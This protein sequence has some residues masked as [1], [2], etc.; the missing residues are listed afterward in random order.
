MIKRISGEDLPDISGNM[1]ELDS[2]LFV[3]FKA[4]VRPNWLAKNAV[5]ITVHLADLAGTNESFSSA[6]TRNSG[7]Y[8]GPKRTKTS[9]RLKVKRLGCR[10]NAHRPSNRAAEEYGRG[11]DQDLLYSIGRYSHFLAFAKLMIP[12]LGSR[13]LGLMNVSGSAACYLFT[14]NCTEVPLPAAQQGDKTEKCFSKY[15]NYKT[16]IISKIF[17][18]Y[19]DGSIPPWCSVTRRPLLICLD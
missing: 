9:A 12:A 3:I 10:E 7:I 14:L 16:L 1:E 19:N 13:T 11:L 17:F 2:Q 18:L 6:P 5:A 4:S 15:H 8:S